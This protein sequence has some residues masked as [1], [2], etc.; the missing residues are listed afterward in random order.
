VQQSVREDITLVK[1]VAP[2]EEYPLTVNGKE[3]RVKAIR[4]RNWFGEIVV[5]KNPENPLVLKLSLNPLT[6][7]AAGA[8]AKSADLKNVF[9]YEIAKLNVHAP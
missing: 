9:G 7:G 2:E 8:V 4:A 3:I 6:Y 1:A 5:L